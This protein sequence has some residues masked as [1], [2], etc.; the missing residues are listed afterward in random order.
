[1][2]IQ[3]MFG[4]SRNTPVQSAQDFKNIVLK[5]IMLGISKKTIISLKE[6]AEC[7][8]PPIGAALIGTTTGLTSVNNRSKQIPLRCVE[9]DINWSVPHSM[10]K[11]YAASPCTTVGVLELNHSLWRAITSPTKINADVLSASWIAFIH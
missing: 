7:S 4:I 9:P 5:N 1:M 3:L 10:K 11:S 2:I 8:E 6:I